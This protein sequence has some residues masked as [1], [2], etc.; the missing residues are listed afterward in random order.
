ML[1]CMYTLTDVAMPYVSVAGV[2]AYS[3]YSRES[4]QQ[5]SSSDPSC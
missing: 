1:N 5:S 4:W 2:S 3:C